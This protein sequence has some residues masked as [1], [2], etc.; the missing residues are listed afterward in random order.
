M[1]VLQQ[2][3]ADGLCGVYALLNFLQTTHW[4]VGDN[5]EGLAFLLDAVRHFRWLTPEKLTNGFEDFELKAILDLQI[6]NWRLGYA[7]YFLEDTRRALRIADAAE[8]MQAV[9]RAGGSAV[10]N[11]DQRS[12]WLLITAADG[13]PVICDSANPRRPISRLGDNSRPFSPRHGLVILP[14]PRPAIELKL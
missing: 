2:G 8:L 11:F 4:S 9:V 1:K 13:E 14:R 3:H 10:V 7:S 6:E 5:R 12:H